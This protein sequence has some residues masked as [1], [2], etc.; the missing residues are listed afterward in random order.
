M[1]AAEIRG[2]LNR[3]KTKVDF[4]AMIAGRESIRSNA[5]V[6]QQNQANLP[7]QCMHPQIPVPLTALVE[8]MAC[9]MMTAFNFSWF[10]VGT[11][12]L[13]WTSLCHAISTGSISR[14]EGVLCDG[15]S[16]YRFKDSKKQC[17][18][19]AECNT[20]ISVCSTRSKAFF[21]RKTHYRAFEKEQ[22][23]LTVMTGK[24]YNG[25]LAPPMICWCW[26]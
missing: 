4:E 20:L 24:G 10:F 12:Q 16:E 2:K 18:S 13:G 7:Q 26:V 19:E 14:K 6:I 22:T 15:H 11:R 17:I 9:V 8:Y 21:Q 23:Q 25:F 5:Q 1:M 3:K